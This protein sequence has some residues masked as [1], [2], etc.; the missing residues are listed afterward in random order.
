MR[1]TIGYLP[2]LALAA[3]A[4][5][6]FGF[7]VFATSATQEAGR[8]NQ[9]ADAIVVLT[10]G[11]NRIVQ[12]GRLLSEGRAGRLLIS[13]VNRKASLADIRRLSRLSPKLFKCCV[14]VGYEAQDT[15]G[16][17]VETRQ[18][19][20]RIGIKRL[21]VV[22]SSYHMPRSL[23]ELR[24]ELPNIELVPYPIVPR[25]LREKPWWLNYELTRIL[26]AEYLKL[27][28][29]AVRF[30]AARIARPFVASQGTADVGLGAQ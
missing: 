28:P 27:V 13:G 25:G 22:T 8:I 4:L 5:L 3:A 29:A 1:K 6:I 24:R 10:G 20:K 16:N 14:E 9:K 23:T 17:A 7:V 18:W 2:W 30:A 19:V 12:A 26:A 21:I 15:I 11:G